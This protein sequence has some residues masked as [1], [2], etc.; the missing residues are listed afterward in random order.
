MFSCVSAK[1][2]EISK[3]ETPRTHLD[4]SPRAEFAR[5]PKNPDAMPVAETA[6]AVHEA[7]VV[8]RRDPAPGIVVLGL[9]A[10]ALASSALPGQFLMAVPP[11]GEA[12]AVALGI[13]EA[14]E[15]RVSIML[16]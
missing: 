4:G 2:R 1:I 15:P 9:H 11:R 8:D 5:A 10:P 3:T 7:V 12:A 16:I 14:S 13:Y 6:P